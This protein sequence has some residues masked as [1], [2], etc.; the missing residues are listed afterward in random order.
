M[1]LHQQGSRGAARFAGACAAARPSPSWVASRCRA[2]APW[3]R[4]Q[5][6]HACR[7]QSAVTSQGSGILALAL[8]EEAAVHPDG[9]VHAVAD[10]ES[11][12]PE[13]R[14]HGE[15]GE[16]GEEQRDVHGA[17]A[18]AKSRRRR[19][20]GEERGR[21]SGPS[22]LRRVRREG[23]RPPPWCSH[24]GRPGV[25]PRGA[26]RSRPRSGTGCDRRTSVQSVHGP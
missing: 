1:S 2:R 24:A 4:P 9:V 19:A 17:K 12:D 26:G 8:G 13:E 16:D 11:D 21:G 22:R 23:A 10:A 7:H 6:A 14:P 5:R 25:S 20:Y 15:Q 18:T 3:E